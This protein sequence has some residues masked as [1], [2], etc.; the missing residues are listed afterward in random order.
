LSV[1]FLPKL[2]VPLKRCFMKYSCYNKKCFYS[3]QQIRI[4]FIP[5]ELRNI[6]C[7]QQGW[8]SSRWCAYCRPATQVVFRNC[9]LN[10]HKSW[11]QQR[12]ESQSFWPDW[13][14]WSV[15][16]F[17]AQVRIWYIQVSVT[18]VRIPVKEKH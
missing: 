10:R 16:W 13:N 4:S 12:D 18:T 11:G 6:L 8:R 3:K 2:G 9:P 1:D 15:I 14:T 17:Q 5:T 7:H